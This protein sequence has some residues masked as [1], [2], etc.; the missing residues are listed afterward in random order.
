MIFFTGAE[1]PNSY[2]TCLVKMGEFK[3]TD[4]AVVNGLQKRSSK[5]LN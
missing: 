4:E 1:V 2:K 3:G 5:G